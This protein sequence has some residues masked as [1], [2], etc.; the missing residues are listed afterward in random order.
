MQESFGQSPDSETSP[1]LI[2]LL[3]LLVG[4]GLGASVA[5]LFAPQSGKKTRRH[6]ET[7]IEESLDEGR[8]KLEP[9]LRR[10]EREFYQFRSKME[11]RLGER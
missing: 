7:A 10:L 9:A 11:D 2:V 1:L 5:L 4:L 6:I 8:D 3:C